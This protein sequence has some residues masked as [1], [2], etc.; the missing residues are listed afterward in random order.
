MAYKKKLYLFHPDKNPLKEI[1]TYRTSRTI[2]IERCDPQSIERGVRELLADKVSGNM[3]G[4]WLMIPEHLRIGTW[5]L[6]Q[7]WTKKDGNQVEPRLAMQLINESSLC[8][9]RIR[10]KHT[11]SQKGFELAN[12]LPFVASDEAIHNLLDEH[13]VAESQQLQIAL[14]KIRQTF[15]HFSGRLLAVDPHRIRTYSN[16]QMV[17]RREDNDSK[18]AK[19]AQT[20]FCLDADT[21]QP[22]CFTTGTSARTVTQA[23]PELLK[24]T[25]EIL[26][27]GGIKPLVL[28]D[29]EHYSSEL[30]DWMFSQSP[31]EMLVPVKKKEVIEKVV[32]ALPPGAFT[33]HW[34]GY[35]TTKTTYH[36]KNSTCGSYYL[37]IQR[38]GERKEEYSFDAFLCT[39]NRNEMEEMALNFPDRWHIEEFFKNYQ[40]L[41]WNR[42]GTMNLNIQ[43]GKMTMT[44]IAQAAIH[45]LRQRIGNPIDEWDSEHLSKDFFKG[46]EGDVRVKGDTIVVTYYNAPNCNLLRNHYESLPEKLLAEGINPAVPWLYNFKLDFRFK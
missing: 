3:V 39:S 31:F 8:V 46:L 34:A 27:I 40:A 45:M 14:G 17:R 10:Q 2:S 12:G 44:L 21:K 43:Y 42:V 23:T 32:E 37:F 15:G 6:L 33:R 26:N 11:L 29:N 41:G 20:F 36:M 38:N 13:T 25:N 7:S 35:A 4:L 9:R 28:A 22:V 30:L 24:L 18:P 5:D 1:E 19:M 16:R